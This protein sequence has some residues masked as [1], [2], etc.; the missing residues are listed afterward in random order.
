M[1]IKGNSSSFGFAVQELPSEE[2]NETVILII[3]LSVLFTL[4]FV[5]Q[6][7][8]EKFENLKTEI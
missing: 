3:P 6:R 5:V 7:L 8:R 4:S 2:A 1:N